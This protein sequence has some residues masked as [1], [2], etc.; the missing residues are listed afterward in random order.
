MAKFIVIGESRTE[1][2]DREFTLVFD[3]E[4][5]LCTWYED[6]GRSVWKS[7]LQIYRAEPVKIMPV[8]E[9]RKVT[10]GYKVQ[11]DRP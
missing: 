4:E 5:E 9:T 7:T 2:T 6:P 3:T 10:V 11:K 1:S 8:T